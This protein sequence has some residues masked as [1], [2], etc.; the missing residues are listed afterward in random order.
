M[1]PYAF[2][3]LCGTFIIESPLPPTPNG[4]GWSTY[5]NTT[6]NDSVGPA[7]SFGYLPGPGPGPPAPDLVLTIGQSAGHVDFAW[8]SRSGMQYDL[9]SSTDLSTDPVTWPP[10]D[11]GVTIHENILPSGTGTNTLAG[12]P[13]VGARRFFAVIEEEIPPLFFED[14]DAEAALP[15]GWTTNGGD[16][17]V[18]GVGV[19]VGAAFGPPTATSLPNCAG[20]NIGAN[21]TAS[22]DLS[23]IS[24]EIA[25]PAS[26]ASLSYRQWRDTEEDG[27]MASIRVLDADNNETL[28][29]ELVTG[30]QGSGGDWESPD[31]LVLP[32]ATNGR[33]VKLEFRFASNDG[34]APS[35][36]GF[37]LDDIRL[38]AN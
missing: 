11:D 15:P 12:L 8:N 10:Y 25:M 1:N 23:L 35:F 30:I 21:Y 37:Y 9:V 28:I 3:G 14:F 20:T 36:A 5:H 26:G 19:P 24:P 2:D 31:P 33:N 6:V 29:E 4:F 32:N 13:R 16:T 7:N 18:W 34:A 38:Q 17:T 22:Q 27:D